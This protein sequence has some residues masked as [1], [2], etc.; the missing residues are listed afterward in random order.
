[1]SKAAILFLC[2]SNSARSQM[3]EGMVR[4]WA[5]AHFEPY[6]AGIEAHG[7]HPLAVQ[8][9]DEIGIDISGHTSKI[10][11][12]YMGRKHFGYLIT[13][14]VDA[15]AACPTTFPGMGQRLHWP[16][17]NPAKAEGNAEAKL[18]KFRAVRDQIRA[19]LTVWLAERG[20]AVAT[21]G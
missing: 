18:A 10:L 19:R 3:A 13:L 4:A 5:G 9:M 8:V 14:C 6:S 15:D 2:Y 11:R 16:F 21:T 20:A 12:E 1:M 7:V 17:D